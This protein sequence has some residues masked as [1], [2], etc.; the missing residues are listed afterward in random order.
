MAALAALLVAGC[1]S[2]QETAAK[3]VA[4]PARVSADPASA[5]SFHPPASLPAPGGEHRISRIIDQ[6]PDGDGIANRRIVIT[7]SYDAAG[8]LIERIREVDREADGIIDSRNVT[9]YDQ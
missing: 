6:D 2:G 8:L 9:Q 1:G 4:G 7:E 3:P 5:V